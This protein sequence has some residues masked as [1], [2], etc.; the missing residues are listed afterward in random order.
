MKQ[1][2][3][4]IKYFT[5]IGTGNYNASTSALYT[6]ISLITSNENIGKD[7]V[8]FFRNMGIDNLYGEYN[9][10]LVAPVSLKNSMIELIEG[11]IEKANKGEETSIFLKMNS[12]TDRQL[13]NALKNASQAGVKIK[14]IIRGICCILPGI[15]E[16]LKI[17]K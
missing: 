8:E 1:E 2:K 3:A 5:Q 17:L 9:N 7:A 14:M 15:K 6:D 10:L 12:L 16:K 4:G 13:M 11:E